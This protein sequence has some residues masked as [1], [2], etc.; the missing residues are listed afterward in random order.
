M[1]N[2]GWRGYSFKTMDPELELNFI[3]GKF[4][5]IDI[6][7]E[8][9]YLLK[10]FRSPLQAQF[11]QYYF[12]FGSVLKFTEHTGYA[13]NSYWRRDLLFRIKN[14]EALHAKAK[15]EMDLETLIIIETG[16]FRPLKPLESIY[17][18]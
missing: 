2:F 5:E 13:C 11:V 17:T 9:R 12:T 3:A 7:K 14:L 4:F 15:A 6:P 16:E 1:D 18:T 10:Y 8:K